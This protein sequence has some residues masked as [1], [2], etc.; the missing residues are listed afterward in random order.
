MRKRS[1]KGLTLAEL[2]IAA[3]ILAFVLSG[4]LLIFINCFFLNDANR[5]LSVATSHAEFVLEQIKNMSYTNFTA[6]SANINAFTWNWHASQIN[7][8]IGPEALNNESI[9]VT[10]SNVSASLLSVVV[11]VTWQDRRQRP[12]NITLETRIAQL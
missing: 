7:S 8:S 9:S 3:A 10:C 6:V 4:L 2:M 5:N 11:N 12:R 1:Q